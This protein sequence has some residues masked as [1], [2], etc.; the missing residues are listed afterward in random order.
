MQ[1]RTR[2][3]PSPTGIPHIGNSRTALF[4]Y[5]LAKKH[6]GRFVLRLEDT[7]QKRIVPESIQSIYDIHQFLELFSDEDP[8]NP[9]KFGPYVQSQRLDIYQKHAQKLLKSGFAY[10]QDG[11]IRVKM[12]NSG[13]I[14]WRDLVQGKISIAN[15]EIDDKV[16][17]KS[18]GFP[19]YHLA[20]VVDDHL[21]KI[22]HVLRGVEWIVSTP[23][24]LYLYQAFNWKP[25]IFAHVPLILGPDRSKLSKRHG[26]KSVLEYQSDGYL[27]QA[28]NNFLF[29]LGNSYQDN[30]N[31]LTLE[32]MIR[33]FDE[34]CLQKQN[35][36]FDIQKLNYFNSAWIKK[37]DSKSLLFFL[38]PFIKQSWVRDKIYLLKVINLSKD[39]LITLADFAN[40][41][42]YF[43]EPPKITQKQILFQSQV[44]KKTTRDWLELVL[45][46]LTQINNFKS[47]LIH[48]ILKQVQEKSPLNPRQAFMT[49]RICLTGQ[50]VTPPLFDILELLGPT[51]SLSRIRK[52]VKLL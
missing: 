10:K 19:T 42:Q 45:A 14:K 3:A 1:V 44:D 31:L 48:N 38:K 28:I 30:S 12:P 23:V 39:R 17:L 34:N 35:A 43:F 2:I 50:S 24:H 26:A 49:L 25:P 18:D 15:K 7:D 41:A 47:E 8:Q 4:N 16:I 52:A 20:V 37:L 51:I 9:G 33:V 21:M 32:E 40:Q 29:Y 27:P 46:E 22:S 5:L 13:Y 6:K 36:I 11:A